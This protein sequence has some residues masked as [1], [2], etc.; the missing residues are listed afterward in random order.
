MNGLCRVVVA[1][2]LVVAAA[3][4]VEEVTRE[5]QAKPGSG[6]TTVD[7]TNSAGNT[8]TFTFSCNG[9]TG[10][11]WGMKLAERDCSVYNLSGDGVSYLYFEFVSMKI[12]GNAATV[13]SAFTNPGEPSQFE[14]AGPS[15]ESGS[16]FQH[17][18]NEFGIEFG[19]HG[20]L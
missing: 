15:V 20:E 3:A 18:I 9:G 2:L 10:E 8:C 4:D 16:S 19:K 11:T 13:R 6:S 14:I 5:F 7:I 17:S 12:E 1:A